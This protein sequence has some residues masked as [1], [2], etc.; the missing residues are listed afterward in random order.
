MKDSKLH[1]LTNSQIETDATEVI[2]L[3]NNPP[4][5]YS[6]IIAEFRCLVKK[7]GNHPIWHS[8]REGNKV[9]HVFATEGS[10]KSLLHQLVFLLNAPPWIVPALQQDKEGYYIRKNVFKS[11][12]L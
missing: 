6:N 5:L 4:P 1:A 12:G 8:F 10:K 2:A 11:P 3:M 7:L 9:A